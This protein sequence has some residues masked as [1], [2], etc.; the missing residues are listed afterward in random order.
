MDVTVEKTSKTLAKVSFN[1]EAQEFRKEYE[2]GLRQ[3]GGNTRL[4]GFRPGKVP[5]KVLEKTHG[6]DVRKQVRE[7]FLQRA[8]Q[9]AVEEE[10]LRPISHPRIDL[11][12][13]NEEEIGGFTLDFE[14]PLRPE[15]ELPEY[16][17]MKIDSELEPVVDG[18][19]ESAL[20]ELRRQQSTPEPAGEEGIDENGVVMCTVT[21]LHGENV[22]LERENLRLSPATPPPGVEPEAFKD[23]LTGSKE[24]DVVELSM[25][26]PETLDDEE[27]RGQEGICRMTVAEAY[28][29]VPPS[30]EDIMKLV[31][32]ESADELHA[33]VRERLQESKGVREQNRIEGALLDKLVET[34]DI[35]LPDTL[36]DEQ[37]EARLKQLHDQMAEQKMDHDEIHKAMDEQ[38]ETARTDAARGLKALLLVETLAEKEELLVT[39]EEM[40]AEFVSIAERNQS[41][42]EEVREYYGRNNL[43]QQ[44]AIEILERKVRTFL[45]E[46]A[47]IIEPS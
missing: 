31:E 33:K 44:M 26:L 28:K 23:A 37:T 8:Y 34:T 22:Q 21:F 6:V 42:V 39:R 18:E 45:R 20:D 29:M 27:A 2:N 41:T 5:L 32:V 10:K 1:V 16:L 11:E 13:L 46:K 47:E 24:G 43:G 19:I 12:K 9:Q 36:L 7:F 14:I 17:G 3:V 15:I 4:K 40:D 35:E 30:E 25:Q 38:R